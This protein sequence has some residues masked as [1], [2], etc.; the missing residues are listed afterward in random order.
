MM[1]SKTKS[2]ISF[3]DLF[4]QAW[5]YYWQNFNRLM[6]LMLIAI[7]V[8]ILG[9]IAVVGFISWDRV[10]SL[11]LTNTVSIPMIGI[12]GSLIMIVSLMFLSSAIILGLVM[13]TAIF[14]MVLKKDSKSSFKQ[15]WKLGREKY[16][17]YFKAVFIAD[18][19][20]LLW[21]LLLIIPGIIKGL[22]YSF[23]GLVALDKKTQ[24]RDAFKESRRLITGRWWGVFWRLVLPTILFSAGTSVLAVIMGAQL[25]N[26]MDPTYCIVNSTA[27]F[28]LTPLFM[29]Y[30]VELYLSLKKTR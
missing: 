3:Q 5:K 9:M 8:G 26:K 29:A 1:I 22:Q 24:S 23:A 7:P 17:A 15:L 19:F 20:T 30:I 6:Q 18:F 10:I 12:A 21:S 13:K 25:G 14:S 11:V 16:E 28:F 27:I 4:A 2:L